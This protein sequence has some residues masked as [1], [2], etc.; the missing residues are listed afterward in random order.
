MQCIGDAGH[1]HVCQLG[2][3]TTA[4][5]TTFFWCRVFVGTSRLADEV[6]CLAGS[7]GHEALG[8]GQAAAESHLTQGTGA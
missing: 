3:L 1:A 2:G 8:P 7:M 6:R 5:G 4:S